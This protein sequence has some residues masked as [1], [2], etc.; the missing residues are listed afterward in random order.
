M[1]GARDPVARRLRAGGRALL[2]LADPV[3]VSILCQLASGPLENAELL[4]RIGFVSR[5]T[6]FERMRDLEELSLISRTR[7][8]DVPP[9]AECRLE[10]A[11]AQ[12][13]PVARRLDAWLA[14]APKGT[15]R[16]G[17]A[18]A[19][20]SV[21]ALAVAWGSTLLRWLAERPRTLS[22]L[23]Q[24][25]HAFGYRKLER[26]VRD[27]VEAGLIE[28]VETRS[29]L[30]PYGVTEWGR[31]AAGLLV[32]AMRW[33]RHE[34]PK[35]SAPVGSMEAEG[36]LL[37]GL[38][39]IALPEEANGSCGLLVDAGPTGEESL[40]GAVVR[41]M[42]GRPVA[43]KAAG[44]LEAESIELEADCW[45]RGPTTAW[46]G[47]H[48]HPGAAFDMG[49]NIDLAEKVMAALREVGSGERVSRLEAT[50]A[51]GT[52]YEF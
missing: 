4:G 23:E 46:L 5:S 8:G 24:L 26:I 19:T 33:E 41:L 25:I 50:P 10:M 11:G 2:L 13:L 44:G 49:N 45:V 12:L 32:A 36:I 27:L 42:D 37:L 20:T 16:L 39:L 43:W 9:I 21:K 1:P 18:Y 38:P 7:R 52:G 17:E 34:I 30:R 15:L 3:S 47:T 6:Y 48:A 31:C 14:E 29:R 51:P 35:R 22:E 28:P 40:G